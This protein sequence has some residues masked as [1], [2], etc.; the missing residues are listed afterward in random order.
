M[1]RSISTPRNHVKVYIS[2]QLLQ[3][4]HKQ[5]VETASKYFP[6]YY[7]EFCKPCASCGVS[8][9]E[10]SAKN[11]HPFFNNNL[12]MLEWEENVRTVRV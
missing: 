8:R 10:H 7:N 2:K 5:D 4:C 1:L 12:E 11:R 9:Y 6:D 3:Q